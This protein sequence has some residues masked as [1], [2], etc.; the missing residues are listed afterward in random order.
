LTGTGKQEVLW[1]SYDLVAVSGAEGK[2]LW[3]AS[4]NNRIWPGVAI[5][6]LTGNGTI[7]IN[8]V[9]SQYAPGV[10][11]GYAHVTR[12]SGTNPFITYA[13]INDGGLAGQR[14]GDGAFLSSAP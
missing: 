14:S 12:T 5:A 8:T 1:G 6:D 9:L 2:L 10:T 13:V 3:R 11:Q 7:Q 4:S